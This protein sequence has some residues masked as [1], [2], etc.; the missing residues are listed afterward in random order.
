MAVATASI[1]EEPRTRTE[2]LFD[3]RVRSVTARVA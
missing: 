3:V 2:T 1:E